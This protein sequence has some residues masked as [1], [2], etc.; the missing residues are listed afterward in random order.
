MSFR[1]FLDSAGDEWQAFDVIPRPDER[2]RYDR[3]VS[4]EHLE[5]SSEESSKESSDRREADRRLTVGRATNVHGT[6][7]W[8]CF[9]RGNDRRRLSPIPPDW[10]WCAEAELETYCKSARAV[11][12]DSVSLKEIADRK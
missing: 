4:G 7:G 3:R 11:R 2:R 9:E 6:E 10:K 8:L 5:G 12:R 1:T